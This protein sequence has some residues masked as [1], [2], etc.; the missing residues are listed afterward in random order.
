MKKTT[1]IL[2]LLLGGFT[3]CDKVDEPLAPGVA[4][5]CDPTVEVPRKVLLEDLTGHLC[6]NCP[7]AA[8]IAEELV[9]L[10]GDK[11]IVTGVHVTEIFAKPLETPAQWQSFGVPDSSFMTDYRTSSGNA[12]H[13]MWT[14]SGLPA[15]LVSRTEFGSSTVLGRTTWASA[16]QQLICQEADFALDFTAVSYDAS[17]RELSTSVSAEARGALTGLYYITILLTE[18]NVVDWQLDAS[19]LPSYVSD[20]EHRHV[21]RDK[22]DAGGNSSAIGAELFSGTAAAGDLFTTTVSNYVLASEWDASNCALVAFVSNQAGEVL[23]VEEIKI[24][25]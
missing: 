19:V 17:A 24:D 1:L 12:I 22:L 5:L 9:D 18:D 14:P 23:Q 16:V 11:L 2:T 10:Y 15:G 8:K 3:A 7:D 6:T 20:Y 13:D 4:T 25:P 21:L